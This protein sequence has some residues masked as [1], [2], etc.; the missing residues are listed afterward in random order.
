MTLPDSGQSVS[1]QPPAEVLNPPFWPGLWLNLLLPGS[2]FTYL[3]QPWWHLATLMLTVV[4]WSGAYALL[5]GGLD[6]NQNSVLNAVITSVAATL[7]YLASYVLLTV[8]YI[9]T[10]RSLE[11]SRP[12]L[13]PAR[14]RWIYAAHVLPLVLIGIVALLALAFVTSMS[15]I[16]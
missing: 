9:Q 7:L 1:S 8:N 4:C 16:Q 10:Y 14:K 11:V 3:D 2:G 12:R 15:N 5:G 6:G 13:S